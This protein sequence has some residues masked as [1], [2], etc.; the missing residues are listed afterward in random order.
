MKITAFIGSGRKQHTYRAAEKFLQNVQALGNVDYEIV[1]LSDYRIDTCRGCRLCLDKGS[2][3]CPL[4]DDRD[5]LIEKMNSS[6]GVVFATPNYAFQV[7]GMMKNFLDRISFIFHRPRYFG[8][9]FTSIVTQGISQ[10]EKINDY[11]DFVGRGLG[12]NTIKGCCVKTLEPITE[13]AKAKIDEAIDSH[14]SKYYKAMTGSKHPVPSLFWLMAFR[15][16]RTSMKKML[17]DECRD[18]IYFRDNGWFESDYFYHV[19]LN[20][21]HKL[22]GKLVDKFALR[23]IR[24]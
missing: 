20:P 15:M 22:A 18:Y 12:F 4:K 16:A 7:S 3:Y 1:R 14:S 8:K 11:L 5:L 10:G 19:K 21:V 17:N 23:L 9:V 6:D 2:E 13:P 24:M